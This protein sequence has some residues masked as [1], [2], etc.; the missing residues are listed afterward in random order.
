MSL[1]SLSLEKKKYL[2]RKQLQSN[3]IGRKVAFHVQSYKDIHMKFLE[4]T[5]D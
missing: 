3:L 4:K 2:T 5:R 1:F